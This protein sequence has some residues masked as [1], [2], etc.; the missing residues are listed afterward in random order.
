MVQSNYK[1]LVMKVSRWPPKR[2]RGPV[3]VT[4]RHYE[5]WS[6]EPIKLGEIKKQNN[7]WVTDDGVRFVSANDAADYYLKLKPI[8]KLEGAQVKVNDSFTDDLK[9]TKQLAK[10]KSN[11]DSEV[12]KLLLSIKN[13]EKRLKD[14]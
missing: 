12:Q 13:I 3:K 11:K 1:G 9:L 10:A 4:E 14:I 8:G 7:Y 5:L 6:L 2:W